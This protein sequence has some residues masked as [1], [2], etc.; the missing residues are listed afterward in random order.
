MDVGVERLAA[1]CRLCKHK[2]IDN[3]DCGRQ[4][5]LLS[6]NTA[7]A[8]PTCALQAQRDPVIRAPE[9]NCASEVATSSSH[10]RQADS[11]LQFCSNPV[12]ANA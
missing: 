6:A 4:S 1:P 5:A 9:P 10:L 11:A 7:D 12:F 3:D 8:E 2:D